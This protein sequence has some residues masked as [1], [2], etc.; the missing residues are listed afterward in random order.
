MAEETEEYVA[1]VTPEDE[2]IRRVTREDAHS[3]ELLHRVAC[4]LVW[5]SRGELLLQR[6]PRAAGGTLGVSFACHV[7]WGETWEQAIRREA[8]EELG[9]ELGQHEE[10]GMSVSE[11][12]GRDRKKRHLMRVFAT[13]HDGSF[14]VASSEVVGLELRPPAEIRDDV[15]RHPERYSYYLCAAFERFGDS[16]PSPS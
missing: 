13:Q 7:Q 4:V 3:Q 14:G 15:R 11:Y 9:I 1:E 8:L 2:V 12:Q 16:L 10:L 5:N 6:R